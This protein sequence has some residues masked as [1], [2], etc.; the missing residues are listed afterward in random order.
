[1]IRLHF[2]GSCR[3]ITGSQY[4]LE[5]P[6]SRVMLDCGLYQG[7]DDVQRRLNRSFHVPPTELDALILSHAHLDHSG[8]VPYLHRQ[9]FRGRIWCHHGTRDLCEILLADAGHLQEEEAAYENRHRAKRHLPP[10]VPLYTVAD[11]QRSLDGFHTV[12][13]GRWHDVT[14][15]VRV[16]FASAGHILGS[17]LV[18][19]EVKLGK[20]WKRLVFTGDLGHHEQVLLHGPETLR[21]ADWLIMESTYGNR[22]Q[23]QRS[24][25]LDQLADVVNQVAARHGVI[26]IPAFAVGR[27]QDVLWGLRGLLREGRIPEIPITL[28]SPMAIAASKLLQRYPHQLRP[29]IRQAFENRHNPLEFAGVSFARSV[30]DSM[31]LNESDGPRIIISASGM[32]TGG[33]ILHHLRRRLPDPA[34][35]LLFVGYQAAATLG[36]RLQE[37]AQLPAPRP[38]EIHGRPVPVQAQITTLETYSAHADRQDLLNWASHF[39]PRPKT[40]FLVHGDPSQSLPLAHELEARFGDRVHVPVAGEVVDLDEPYAMGR[41]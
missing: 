37:N 22:D 34:N 14:S 3:G 8:L 39:Q 7:G 33:R 15:D 28:D 30:Q 18:Q 23:A 5:T 36:R 35:A 16:C 24:A 27:T 12:D 4:I 19:L 2:Y 32:C 20:V 38:V 1:V 9:G 40:I 11:A 29:E 6:R 13:Y 26:L 17:S 31:A 41:H 21:E 25:R 10:V